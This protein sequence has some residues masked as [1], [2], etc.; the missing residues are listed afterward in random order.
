MRRITFLITVFAFVLSLGAV[1]ASAGEGLGLGLGNFFNWMRDADG[2]G[3]PNCLDDDYTPPQDGSG[4]Q[5]RN[6]SRWESSGTLLEDGGDNNMHR[7][8]YRKGNDDVESPGDRLRL[9]TG[10]RDGSCL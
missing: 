2:D 3:I 1:Q 5:S 4:N 6:G 8:N 9:R 7:K 10:S